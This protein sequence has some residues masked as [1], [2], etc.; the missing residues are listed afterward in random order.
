MATLS[1]ETVV[2]AGLT[3]TYNTAADPDDFVNTGVEFIHV[4]NG[5]ASPI[6]L[7]ILTP[8]TVDGLAVADRVVVI[9]ATDEE[10]IGPFPTSVY[11]NTSTNKVTLNY[12]AVTSV[13]IAVLKLGS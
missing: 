7:T 10:M 4:K 3:P 11:N 5:D 13:T 9:G 1:V 2:R 12:S 8:Q 6:N